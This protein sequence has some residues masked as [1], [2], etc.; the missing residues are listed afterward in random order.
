M[1]PIGPLILCLVV[2]PLLAG[3]QQDKKDIE[4][5]YTARSSIARQTVSIVLELQSGGR[6]SWSI[7]EDRLPFTWQVKGNELWLH[8]RTGGIIVGQISGETLDLKLPGVGSFSFTR[9]Q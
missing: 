9:R 3:C 6:G 8:T 7:E 5:R 4:G 2:V 1:R